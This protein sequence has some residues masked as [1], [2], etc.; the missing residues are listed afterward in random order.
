[1]FFLPVACGGPTAHPVTSTT[2]SVCVLRKQSAERMEEDRGDTLSDAEAPDPES[3]RRAKSAPINRVYESLQQLVPGGGALKARLV[4]TPVSGPSGRVP[5]E[6]PYRTAIPHCFNCYWRP[7]S[8]TG[9][10]RHNSCRNCGSER[11]GFEHVE[12][13]AARRALRRCIAADAEEA[14]LRANGEEE[15]RADA[16][17]VVLGAGTVDDAFEVAPSG[18]CCRGGCGLL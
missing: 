13:V 6:S 18:G 5:N 1:V 10:S 7:L 16:D 15:A 4:R 3:R 11:R 14:A 9:K 2:N 17:E 8:L 12:R